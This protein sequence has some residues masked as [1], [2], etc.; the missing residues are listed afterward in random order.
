M[1]FH[2]GTLHNRKWSRLFIALSIQSCWLDSIR[3]Y[4]QMRSLADHFV[5][6]TD[7]KTIGNHSLTLAED[8]STADCSDTFTYNHRGIAIQL[9]MAISGCQK[10]MC[11]YLYKNQ[12][13]THSNRIITKWRCAHKIAHVS[14]FRHTH[15]HT[16]EI[17][18]LD[19]LLPVLNI[20]VGH[21]LAIKSI[22]LWT[23]AFRSL[24][25]TFTKTEL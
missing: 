18:P 12:H 15:T 11:K 9:R 10:A 3:W 4:L 25:L 20:A 7:G 1:G 13:R 2:F 21:Y 8:T 23:N 22:S 24:N 17:V 14:P 5:C 6:Q 16:S 19:I